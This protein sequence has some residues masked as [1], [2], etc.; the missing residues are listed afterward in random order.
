MSISASHPGTCGMFVYIVP[1]PY[2]SRYTLRHYNVVPVSTLRFAVPLK[3][4]ADLDGGEEW[5]M[6]YFSSVNLASDV[7][8]FHSGWLFLR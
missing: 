8:F 7:F 5:R 3:Q 2:P 6:R 1:I 4:S